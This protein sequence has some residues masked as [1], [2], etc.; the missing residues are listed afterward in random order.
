M[1]VFLCEHNFLELSEAQLLLSYAKCRRESVSA[2]L[3]ELEQSINSVCIKRQR[4]APDGTLLQES[5][6]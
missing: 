2:R 3:D 5:R 6:T 1:H 4:P